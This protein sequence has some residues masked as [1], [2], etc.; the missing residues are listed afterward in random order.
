M[1]N[2]NMGQRR[3]IILQLFL[4]MCERSPFTKGNGAVLHEHYMLGSHV[5]YAQLQGRLLNASAIAQQ[6]RMP[7]PTVARKLQ[8][9]VEMGAVTKH[10]D[11]TYALNPDWLGYKSGPREL[12]EMSERVQRAAAELDRLDSM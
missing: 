12:R 1:T 8:E 2:E 4:H 7:R 3:L 5:L 10:A 6:A 9:M 11:A